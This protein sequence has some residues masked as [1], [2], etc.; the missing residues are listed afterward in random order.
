M[1]HWYETQKEALKN[2]S[3]GKNMKNQLVLYESVNVLLCRLCR[4]HKQEE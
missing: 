1:I 2:L 4:L 3:T